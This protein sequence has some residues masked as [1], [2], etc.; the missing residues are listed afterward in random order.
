MDKKQIYLN[1][2]QIETDRSIFLPYSTG[3]LQAYA[4]CYIGKYYEFKPIIFRKD[5]ITNIVA[6]YDNPDVVGFST[7][8][9]NYQLSLAVAKALKKKFPKCY[10][11]FGGPCI[12]K[13]NKTLFTN[14]P[15]IDLAIYGEGEKIFAEVLIMKMDNLSMPH[16]I[17]F[18]SHMINNAFETNLDCFVSPYIAGVYDK[19]MEDN[20]Q[21]EFKALVECNRNCPFGCDYCYWGQPE[22]KKR[23]KY[24]SADYICQDA[25]WIAKHKIDY[26]F[27]TDANFG[28]FKRD[29]KTAQTYADIKQQYDYPQKFRVCYGKNAANTIFDTASILNNANMDKLITLSVQSTNPDTLNAVSRTN[30][31]QK[32]FKE[33]QNRYIDANIS[34]YTEFILPLPLETKESFYNGLEQTIKIIKHN[35]IFVYP[36]Q[37]L[38]NTKLSSQEYRK[39]YKLITRE[40]P[41]KVPHTNISSKNWTQEYDEVIV[42][43]STMPIKDFIE[44]MAMSWL[45]QLFHSFKI[46][47]D[48]VN[49]LHNYYNMSYITIYIY[50]LYSL[51][52]G[53]EFVD[54]AK[55][56]THNQHWCQTDEKFGHVYYE[57][58]ELIY[59]NILYNKDIFYTQLFNICFQMIKIKDKNVYDIIEQTKN[60]LPNTNSITNWKTFALNTVIRGG[61]N[62]EQA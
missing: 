13:D 61:K 14:H 48:L 30:I 32:T 39:K 6:Q 56:M 59:L 53:R 38:P 46:G 17:T 7:V 10:I 20:P 44:C 31:K 28:M 4:E 29:T 35:Q 22:L 49:Y 11:I 9:W 3:L 52:E 62:N 33:L 2:Y 41:L 60:E 54:I 24:H 51:N 36:C 57:P 15:Y 23:I 40:M 25:E 42:G 27:C 58:E 1:E 8:I 26:V 16:H 18:Y 37:V 47:Y 34:T 50:F 43:T 19:L 12:K 45:I 21:L 55:N 5:T